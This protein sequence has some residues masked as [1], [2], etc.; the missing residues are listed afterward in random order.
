[1]NFASDNWAGVPEEMIEALAR[2]NAGPVPAYGGDA[3]T[4]DVEKRFAEVFET[5]L[6]VLF[7]A[8]GTAANSLSLAALTPPYG[9]I[10]CHPESHIME[11][12]GGAPEFFSGG[13]RLA[14]VP[15]R[16]G[17]IDASGL[18]AALARFAHAAGR[19]QPPAAV[20]LTQASEAG[21]LY[22]PDEIAAI[23]ELC[24]SHGLRLHMDGARFA[25]AVAALGCAPA[26]ITWRAGV[27]LLSF[28]ATKNGA[29]A[30]E[31]IVVFGNVDI[32]DLAQRRKQAGHL[33][34]KS[35]FVA[36]QFE[37][38][39]HDGLWLK[40]AAHA[41]AMAARLAGGLREIA[42]VRLAYPVEANEVFAILPERLAE[43]LAEGGAV[44][45]RWPGGGEGNDDSAGPGE[46]MVRLV[47]SFATS[48]DDVD[49][50]LALARELA[51]R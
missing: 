49:A 33:L 24:R 10:L 36:A 38:C 30:A 14:A 47:A 20:S 28:G 13:A 8:T 9:V 45:Y 40:L 18:E 15:G 31:A 34:S 29:L 1:M 43:G 37:A 42:P 22:R 3:V 19:F 11:D 12:E 35:R 6:R 2:A 39:F 23:G 46:V 51:V 27:D 25:N 50:F 7:V 41:N 44:Y 16:N 4:A 5:D 17:K 26:D 48:E 32:N 21:T